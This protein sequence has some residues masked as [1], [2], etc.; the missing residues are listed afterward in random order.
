MDT[1]L[2]MLPSTETSFATQ[3]PG[4]VGVGDGDAQV[5]KLRLFLQSDGQSPPT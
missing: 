4:P 5:T 1:S 2:P 3:N